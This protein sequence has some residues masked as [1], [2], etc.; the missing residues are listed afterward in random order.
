MELRHLRYFIAVAE[1]L[2]F[3]RAAQ[4]L[5]ISQP[6]LSQQIQALE[7]QLGARLFERTNRRVELSE[8]GRLFL[9]EA[10]QVLAQVDKATDVARRAQL[11]QL[12]ELKIGFTAS[13]PFMSSI[14][15][16]I[17]RFRQTYPDVHLA[18][19]EMTSQDV[20]ACLEDQSIRVGIMRPL[21]LPD[22]LTAVELLRDPLMAILRAD[23][24]LATGSEQG[25]SLSALAN[26]PFVFFPRSY[27]SGLHAQLLS[28]ARAAGFSPLITQEAGEVM[29]I[30]G[31]VAAGLGV[32]V[33]PASYQRMR[34]DGV[35]YRT[36]LDPGATSAVWLA[37]RKDE[38]SPMAKAFVELVTRQTV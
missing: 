32:T 11:G 38:H 18:L 8:A 10:R 37:Q 27:G 4:V 30:I 1:E 6:P 34:I 13:A 19:R 35:V 5:G 24:P 9:D 22:S 12:G 28:L 3:G 26:E 17:L 25:L 31:L 15:Q 29:T 21:P 14:P 2:H 7:Q 23:H 33:L 20:I 16:A 36:L